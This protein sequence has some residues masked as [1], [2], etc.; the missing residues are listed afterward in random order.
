MFIM[1]RRA[2]AGVPSTREHERS[3]SVFAQPLEHGNDRAWMHFHTA[4]EIA[5]CS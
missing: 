4:S 3:G 1:Q 5:G 2:A